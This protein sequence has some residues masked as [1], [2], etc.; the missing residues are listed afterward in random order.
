MEEILDKY[1][2]NYVLIPREVRLAYF[3][4]HCG[5]W[6]YV[7][8]DDA[9]VTLFECIA[10]LTSKPHRS[11]EHALIGHKLLFITG[12]EKNVSDWQVGRH[13]D[14]FSR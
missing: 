4:Q 11:P 1:N 9:S 13:S 8:A 7:Y 5:E 10:P 12:D 6:R 14:W 2:I 3:I